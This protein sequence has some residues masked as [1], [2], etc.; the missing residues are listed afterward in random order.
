VPVAYEVARAL[1]APLDLLLVRKLGVPQ[2]PEVGIG[3]IA[4]GAEPQLVLN[5]AIIREV[6]VSREYLRHELEQQ[7]AELRRRRAVYCGNRPPL[8]VEGRCIIL[9]DDG[10]ATGSTIEA[11]LRALRQAKAGYLALAV[12]VAP[13][14][15]L[16]VL[17]QA[18]DEIICLETPEPFIAVGLHYG[19]FAQVSDDQVKEFMARVG[20]GELPGFA[21]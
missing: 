11:A 10:I 16:A 12:P 18:C 1:D 2:N 13:A 9:V 19:D 5:A 6:G 14:D 21:Q 17:R 7:L 15:T 8:A 4:D 3:A 20:A